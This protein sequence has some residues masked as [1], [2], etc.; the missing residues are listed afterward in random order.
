MCPPKAPKIEYPDPP[1]P[2]TTGDGDGGGGGIY[3]SFLP[4]ETYLQ[5]FHLD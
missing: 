3:Y 2:T 4:G 1:A 5:A